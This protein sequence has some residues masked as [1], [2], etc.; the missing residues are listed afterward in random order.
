MNST[1][2]ALVLRAIATGV[3]A[4]LGYLTLNVSGAGLDTETAV[5]AGG[6]TGLIAQFVQAKFLVD[7][8]D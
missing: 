6:I 7:K 5:L 8:E 3:V 2:V 4:A 1:I